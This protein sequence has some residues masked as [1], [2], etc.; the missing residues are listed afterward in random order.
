MNQVSEKIQDVAASKTSAQITSPGSRLMSLDALRGF[1]MFWIVGAGSLVSAFDKIFN[2]AVTKFLSTQCKHVQWEGF[3]FE[4]LIFPLFIFIAGV[5]MTFSMDK[6][7]ARNGKTGAMIRLGRRCILLILLGIFY[8]GGLSNQ[9]PGIRLTGVLQSIGLSCFIAGSLYIVFNQSPRVLVF[10]FLLLLTGY[11]ALL[12][13][14]SFPDVRLNKDSLAKVTAQIGSKDPGKVAKSITG[15]VRGVYEEGYNLSNYVDYR[16]LPG[17]KLY[18]DGKYEAQGLLQTMT[19]ASSCL[20]GILAGLWLRREKNSDMHKVLGLCTAGVVSVILGFVW[21][22]QFPV[23]K[24]IW[25]S[26]FV[27][28]AGGYSAILLGLFYYIVDIRKKQHWCLPFVWI[29]MNPITIYLAHNIISFPTLAARLAGGDLQ[30]FLDVHIAKG[31]GSL[32]IAIVEVALTFLLVRFLYV[33][34][35]FIRL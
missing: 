3:H 25:S 35:I 2:N 27:L 7:I 17:K 13:F 31:S 11:W 5:S 34:K 4:D 15:R 8:Y 24:K 9:W 12:T 22:L 23:V 29:G 19:A 33:R 1:D 28:V 6:A 16:F 30:R 32:L 20:L 18:G 26:S 10:F 21:G 14:V